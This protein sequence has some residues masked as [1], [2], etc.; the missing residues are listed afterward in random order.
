MRDRRRSGSARPQ[1]LRRHQ[2][3]S[4][5]SP[6]RSGCIRALGWRADGHR[7]RQAARRRRRRDGWVLF[8]LEANDH[9]DFISSMRCVTFWV[10]AAPKCHSLRQN[11]PVAASRWVRGPMA[12][13]ENPSSGRV[14][15]GDLIAGMG[16]WHFG[17]SRAQR[18]S[19]AATRRLRRCRRRCAERW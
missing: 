15:D 14:G 5:T 4:L 18:L 9:G 10:P 19:A 17:P 16:V 8:D 3:M 6:K 1:T 2:K 7:R 13:A 11:D 12:T